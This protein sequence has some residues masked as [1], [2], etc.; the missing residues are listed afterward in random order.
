MTFATAPR[1]L[2][3]VYLLLHSTSYA[4][5]QATTVDECS[6]ED[7]L[8]CETSSNRTCV[9]VVAAAAAGAAAEP[10]CGYCIPGHLEY[11]GACYDIDDMSS[12]TDSYYSSMLED[13]LTAYLPDYVDQDN[14][15]FPSVS[16]GGRMMRLIAAARVIS[17]WNSM[18]PPPEFKLG[19]TR[20][21]L[22]TEEEFRGGRLGVN[23]N[24]T[25]TGGGGD[26]SSGRGEMPRFE[27]GGNVGVSVG[28][29]G[30]EG[31]PPPA[32]P[33]VDWA[34][35][36]YTTKVK[37]QGMCGCCWAVSTTASVE[38]ALMITNRT[39]RFDSMDTNSL[40]FQQLISCD[41]ESGNSGCDGGNILA[42]T[43][44]IWEHDQFGNGGFGGLVSYGERI[45]FDGVG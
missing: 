31:S 15:K 20:E 39:S 16:S 26:G 42:A 1:I 45:Y 10:T 19:F 2:L 41:D 18:T 24:L 4:S 29:R 25:T 43:R 17:Y 28:G 36:G 8:A 22:L 14:P 7:Q 32:A 30:F 44:Y 9:A 21:S 37:N 13:I 38:S 27:Y 6:T 11:E 23:Y 3:L 12:T 34:A 35:D 33:A 40:S 5:G